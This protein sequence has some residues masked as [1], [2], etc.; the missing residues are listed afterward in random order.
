MSNLSKCDKQLFKFYS[1]LFL[2]FLNVNLELWN[3]DFAYDNKGLYLE[4]DPS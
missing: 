3:L 1:I 2:M 4:I